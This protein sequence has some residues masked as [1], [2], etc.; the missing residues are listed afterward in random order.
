M[1][2]FKNRDTH[3]QYTGELFLP[4][5]FVSANGTNAAN[6]ANRANWQSAWN[7]VTVLAHLVSESEHFYRENKSETALE[8]LVGLPQLNGF[9]LCVYMGR[10]TVALRGNVTEEK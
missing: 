2:D 10:R 1:L 9:S 6:G 5:H 7:L 8:Q 4:A 3:A